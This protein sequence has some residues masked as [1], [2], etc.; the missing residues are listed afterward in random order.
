MREVNHEWFDVPTTEVLT[1]VLGKDN[2]D[3]AD[4]IAKK[5]VGYSVSKEWE[6][7]QERKADRE[8]IDEQGKRYGYADKGSLQFPMLNNILDDMDI[9]SKT[10]REER[11]FLKFAAQGA[12]GR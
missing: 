4:Y 5:I 2:R 11:G 9:I 10:W 7:K 6:I 1:A 3:T 8:R 12:G